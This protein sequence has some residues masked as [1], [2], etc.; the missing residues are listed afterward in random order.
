MATVAR[1]E[2]QV[3][4][5]GASMDEVIARYVRDVA[6]IEQALLRRARDPWLARVA[7]WALVAEAEERDLSPRLVS[8]VLRVENPWL[9]T[10]TTS[11]AG[12][13]GWMQVM[14]LH[15]TDDHP[16]GTDL[17]DGPTSV[18]Y[19]SAILREYIGRALDRAVRE[20]LNA[21]NGC[22]R[23]PGCESYATRV[24]EQIE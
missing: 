7:S 14:P 20:G 17:T 11:S 18:C 22:V 6:P 19:G 12:A 1:M 15:V 9:A 16:C 5:L 24:T 23:T 4:L 10:D 3:A 2:R 21:Y 13:V 8:K